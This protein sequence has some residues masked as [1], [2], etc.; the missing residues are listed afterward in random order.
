MH[1]WN[2][3]IE[4]NFGHRKRIDGGDVHMYSFFCVWSNNW[5]N[6][7]ANGHLYSIN[8]LQNILFNIKVIVFRFIQISWDTINSILK[9]IKVLPKK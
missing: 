4:T 6:Q 9:I 8:V 5:T 2:G 1:Q 3:W 7:Q